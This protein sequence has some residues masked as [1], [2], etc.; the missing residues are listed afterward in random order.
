MSIYFYFIVNSFRFLFYLI[1]YI[2][3]WKRLKESHVVLKHTDLAK[4]RSLANQMYQKG[5]KE[6]EVCS[7]SS[8]LSSLWFISVT[9]WVSHTP[10][11]MVTIS[12]VCTPYTRKLHLTLCSPYGFMKLVFVL[13][14]FGSIHTSCLSLLNKIPSGFIV[15]FALHSCASW[16]PFKSEHSADPIYVCLL[17]PKNGK[18]PLQL[19]GTFKTPTNLPKQSCQPVTVKVCVLCSPTL[20]HKLS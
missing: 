14:E 13:L 6:G 4:L 10:V 19:T 17:S 15:Q 18:W 12:Q 1:E 7:L 2:Q 9:Q 20:K 5:I 11:G 8:S 3:D 16:D